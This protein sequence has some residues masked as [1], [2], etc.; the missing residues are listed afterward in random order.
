[1]YYAARANHTGAKNM[2][3]AILDGI[4]LNQDAKG[5]SVPETKADYNRLDDAGL[6]AP[7]LDRHDAERRPDQLQT[8]PSCRSARSTRTTPTS[9]KVQAYLDG[10]GPAPTF[11]YHRFWAQVD[12]AVAMGE[13]GRLFPNG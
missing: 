10:T 13:Y 3:K 5:V 7:G 2:A 8:R 12:V 6:R 1:M 11:N 4:W 9:P